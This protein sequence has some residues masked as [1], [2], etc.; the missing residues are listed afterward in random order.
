MTGFTVPSNHVLVFYQLILHFCLR[1]SLGNLDKITIKLLVFTYLVIKPK[2]RD[3]LM[4]KV[5]NKG[6]DR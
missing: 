2:N 1:R 3:H 5:R 6:Y 4:N